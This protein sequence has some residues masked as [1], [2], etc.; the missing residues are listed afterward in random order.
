MVGTVEA[1]TAALTA[2][3]AKR[4]AFASIL[5]NIVMIASQTSV[6]FCT[7]LQYLGRYGANDSW[8]LAKGDAFDGMER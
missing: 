6:V 4:P 1:A 5:E 2:K 8:V 3:A 7:V